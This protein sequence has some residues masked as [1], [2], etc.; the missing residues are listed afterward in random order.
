MI[1]LGVDPVNWYR[2]RR[3]VPDIIPRGEA[4]WKRF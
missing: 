3:V 4:G 2:L 1:A